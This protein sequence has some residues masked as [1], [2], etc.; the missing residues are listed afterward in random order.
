MELFGLDSC[1]SSVSGFAM[2]PKVAMKANN[3][4]KPVKGKTLKVTKSNLNKLNSMTLEEKIAKIKKE[5]CLTHYLL[6]NVVY[7][8]C[9]FHMLLDVFV[10]CSV[11]QQY[12][13]ATV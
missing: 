2:A 9:S 6:L 7:I 5:E 10:V 12:F 8:N 13:C 3:S 11:S 4:V 1:D